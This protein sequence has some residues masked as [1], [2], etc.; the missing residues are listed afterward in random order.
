MQDVEHVHHGDATGCA[1]NLHCAVVSPALNHIGTLL[2]NS[3]SSAACNLRISQTTKPPPGGRAGRATT[4]RGSC[5]SHLRM[6][7]WPTVSDPQEGRQ[8]NSFTC[9]RT[10]NLFSARFWYENN[11]PPSAF[12]KGACQVRPMFTTDTLS[13][14]PVARAEKGEPG[15]DPLR[16]PGRRVHGPT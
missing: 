14:R 3:A 1:A 8:V 12:T 10:F 7:P 5:R 2:Q 16:E 15:F 9:C 11:I 4:F 6:P 13:R